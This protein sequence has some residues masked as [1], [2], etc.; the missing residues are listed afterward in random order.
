MTKYIKRI[1]YNDCVFENVG[2]GWE[3]CIDF[4][5]VWGWWWGGAWWCTWWWGWWWLK[6]CNNYKINKWC[7]NIVIWCGWAG[8]SCNWWDSCFGNIIVC[9][10][11]GWG[12]CGSNWS[13]W[14][15]GWWG[16]YNWVWWCWING[17]GCNW[18]WNS[19]GWGWGW[20][21][22][23]G[24]GCDWWHWFGSNIMWWNM[25][26]F[27]WWWNWASCWSSCMTWTDWC[28]WWGWNGRNCS[29]MQ[30]VFVV[31]YKPVNWVSIS[32]W[33]DVL[34]VNGRCI[35]IFRNDGTLCVE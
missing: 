28:Y 3:Q 20:A 22:G 10:W 9:G 23:D 13:D 4:L 32:W 24:V 30:W 14:G 12:E 8:G 11:W 15:S 34:N 31:N 6:Y 19:Y 7:Y 2:W 29:G 5:L 33:D 21:G 35:H 26:Y 27:G 25:V 16:G 17:Q 1:L 18:S